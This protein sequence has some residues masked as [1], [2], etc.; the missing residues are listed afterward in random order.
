HLLHYPEAARQLPQCSDG[1]PSGRSQDHGS[2]RCPGTGP[3]SS[4]DNP[5]RDRP[6]RKAFASPPPEGALQNPGTVLDP[7]PLLLPGGHL[8]GTD[9]DHEG[10]KE[11][12]SLSGSAD[13]AC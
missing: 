4:G 10:R 5:L 1:R 12:L 2:R 6:L 11:N 3:C 9:P 8:S 13:P 7:D